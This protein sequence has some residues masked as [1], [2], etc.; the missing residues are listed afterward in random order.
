[1][2]DRKRWGHSDDRSLVM[3]GE[4]KVRR[5]DVIGDWHGL[6]D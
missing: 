5:V 1:M 2:I 4:Q 6:R 3:Y